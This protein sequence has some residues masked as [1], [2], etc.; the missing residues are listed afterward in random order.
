M[1][2]VQEKY[3]QKGRFERFRERLRAEPHCPPEVHR[4]FRGEL[5]RNAGLTSD[6]HT[7]RQQRIK[8]MC[9]TYALCRRSVP[10]IVLARSGIS[11]RFALIATQR[12]INV[13][14]HLAL[15]KSGRC[16]LRVKVR[17]ARCPTR[18]VWRAVR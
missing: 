13:I 15:K 1:K 12:F 16:W 7:G 14:R 18:R 17:W 2:S 4:T 3:F 5:C 11:G 6:G 9:T 10:G 8:L